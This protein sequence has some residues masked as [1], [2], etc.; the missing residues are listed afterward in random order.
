M[1]NRWLV[2]TL[3]AGQLSFP[4]GVGFPHR[5]R[6]LFVYGN[7]G[8]SSSR[9]YTFILIDI[10]TMLG[11]LTGFQL[12]TPQI[13]FKRFDFPAFIPDNIEKEN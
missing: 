4:C 3:E 9:G 12:D 13:C 11:Y 2:R 8:I 5:V 10:K 1:I 7:C 6:Y